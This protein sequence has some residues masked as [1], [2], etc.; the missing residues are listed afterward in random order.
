MRLSDEEIQ[1]LHSS[2]D[3]LTDHYRLYLFGS[4]VDDNKRGG[5]IDLLVVSPTLRRKDLRKIRLDFFEHFGEQ[6]LDILLDDGRYEDP[7]VRLILP[8]AI[9]L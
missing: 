8:E 2:L 7:F 3:S 5:D 9:E 6:K 1:V 4:R